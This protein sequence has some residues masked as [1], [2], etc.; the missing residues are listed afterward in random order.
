M[1]QYDVVIAGGAMAGAT[2]ALAIDHL[3]QESSALPS[4]SLLKRSQIC[5]LVLTLAQSHC[6]TVLSIC[7]VN[8]SSGLQ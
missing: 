3:S 1:K 7:C 4:L 2:L 8:Y 6:L 5:T